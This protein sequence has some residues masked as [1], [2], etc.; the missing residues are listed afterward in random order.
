MKPA[1]KTP[2]RF[3]ADVSEHLLFAAKSAKRV[4]DATGA[5]KARR[6]KEIAFALRREAMKLERELV[7]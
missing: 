2:L 7:R 3:A 1:A 4:E 5:D 6:I